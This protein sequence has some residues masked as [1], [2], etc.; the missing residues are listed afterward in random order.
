MSANEKHPR[1][2]ANG[3][4]MVGRNYMFHNSIA[5]VA[6]SRRENPTVFQKT[7]TINDFYLRAPDY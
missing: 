1:G 6:L 4:D 3:S 5:L 7:L 2:L